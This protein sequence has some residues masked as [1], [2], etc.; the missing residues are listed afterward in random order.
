MPPNSYSFVFRS[1]SAVI[2]QKICDRVQ[3]TAAFCEATEW[4]HR[5]PDKFPHLRRNTSRFVSLASDEFANVMREVFAGDSVVRFDVHMGGVWDP[6][7]VIR[8]HAAQ[9]GS[10]PLAWEDAFIVDDIK[11]P[12]Q[13]RDAMWKRYSY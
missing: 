10:F 5:H 2:T 9:G 13:G 6:E 8:E 12:P 7:D 11:P 1:D 4:L 3:K